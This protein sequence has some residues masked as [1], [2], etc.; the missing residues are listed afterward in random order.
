[1]RSFSSKQVTLTVWPRG[2]LAAEPMNGKKN[3]SAQGDEKNGERAGGSGSDS[4]VTESTTLKQYIVEVMGESRAKDLLL[5]CWIRLYVHSPEARFD[6]PPSDRVLRRVSRQYQDTGDFLDKSPRLLY[7]SRW[8]P[9]KIL[10][11]QLT[12]TR[13]FTPDQKTGKV[14]N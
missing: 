4:T 7:D 3:P 9:N 11:D 12:I 10:V 1:M 8:E 13:T 14:C 5:Q 2:N 6:P